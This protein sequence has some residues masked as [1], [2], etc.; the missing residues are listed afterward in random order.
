MINDGQMLF[1]PPALK[2]FEIT[3]ILFRFENFRFRRGQN[4]EFIYSAVRHEKLVSFS[5]K[6]N[7][8]SMIIC[9]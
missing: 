9:H 3:S 1:D 2:N 8:L 6:I 4:F 5:E 7:R